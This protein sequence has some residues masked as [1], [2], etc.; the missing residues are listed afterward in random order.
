[1]KT[2]SPR[3]FSGIG[4]R[5]NLVFAAISAIML[6]VM[7]LSWL[8]FEELGGQINEINEVRVPSLSKTINLFSIADDFLDVGPDLAEA[9]SESER[10]AISARMTDYLDRLSKLNELQN[11][12]HEEQGNR[13]RIEAL[14]ENLHTSLAL[15]NGTAQYRLR[16]EASQDEA[17]QRLKESYRQFQDTVFKIVSAQESKVL[18]L[19]ILQIERLARDFYDDLYYLAD[20][21]S[22]ERLDAVSAALA[23]KGQELLADISASERQTPFL[24][25]PA[26]QLIKHLEGDGN[27]LFLR[28]EQLKT[29][30]NIDRSLEKTRVKIVQIRLILA[31]NMKATQNA[32][33]QS[34]NEARKLISLRTTQLA[35]SVGI[36]F[37]LSFIAS[38]IFVRRSIVR[39]LTQLG[40]KMNRIA[41]GELDT[42]IDTS[43]TDEISRMAEAL[44]VFRTTAREVEEQQTR[45]IIESSVAGLVMTDAEGKIEFLSHTARTL[46]GYAYARQGPTPDLDITALVTPSEGAAI[47][48]MLEESRTELD[49][50]GQA[51]PA[52]MVREFKACRRDGRYFPSDVAVRGIQQRSGQKF[53]FTIYD[54]TDRKQAQENL[55]QTVAERTTELRQANE[56]LRHENETRI[57]TESAL[58]STKEELIQASKLAALGKM[59]SGISHE[60]NQPLMAVASW[61]HNVDLLL[62]RGEYTDAGE[63]LRNIQTQ[64]E[65]M[66]ELASHLQTLAR[67]P[68][69]NFSPTDLGH[70][71]GRAL[72]LFQVRIAQEGASIHNSDIL[73]GILVTTDGLRLE[74]VFIN[75]IANAL[76]ATSR[77]NDKHISLD[78]QEH[79]EGQVAISVYD[80]GPGI[81]EETLKNVFDPFYTTKE[82]GKGMGLGLSISYNIVRTLGG[83]LTVSNRGEGGACFTLVLP[84]NTKAA[85]LPLQA[86]EIW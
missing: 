77:Q 25:E 38:L 78:L 26:R 81:P 76:D 65:R 19:E 82:V 46:F 9:K 61:L 12:E 31:L 43:G 75:L 1:M 21:K 20:V 66:I 56:E 69:L 64:V 36:V 59:A 86:E 83:S 41:A 10:Q 58:R 62:E 22:M 48:K 28:R 4:A 30:L 14:I 45:A 6:V 5:V 7:L 44:E 16:L 2:L 57:R 80:N 17:L 63:A 52:P 42:M 85:N 15:L 23:A 67:Q 55:E 8:A 84:K 24:T 60:F 74:Q 3:S 33:A 27:L 11:I 53:I 29:A 51:T 34:S 68:V 35:L 39:R 73:D 70:V 49:R 54:V 50:E 13:E 72:S 18:P 47:L 37:V 79:R 32:I 71:L 40:D